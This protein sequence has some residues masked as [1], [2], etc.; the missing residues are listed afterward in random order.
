MK[1]QKIKRNLELVLR[2]KR[3][4]E[5]CDNLCD[6]VAIIFLFNNNSSIIFNYRI[7]TKKI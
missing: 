6:D 1:L 7:N 5:Y 2:R 3:I 4:C